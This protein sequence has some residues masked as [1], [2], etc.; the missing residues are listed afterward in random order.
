MPRWDF[1]FSF[2]LPLNTCSLHK[3]CVTCVSHRSMNTGN[4][5]PDKGPQDDLTYERMVAGWP[6]LSSEVTCAIRGGRNL[7]C[8]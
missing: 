2:L 7:C 6:H 8:R 5:V 1:A 4:S 3:N